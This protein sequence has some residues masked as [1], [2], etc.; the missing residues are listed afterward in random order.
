SAADSALG[1][2]GQFTAISP[3]FGNIGRVVNRSLD[4]M[5]DYTLP[6]QQFGQWRLGLAASRTLE[7]TKQLA[8]GQP[9]VVL[10][11][12]TASPPVWKL[13]GSL[14]WKK[15]AWNAALFYSYLDGFSNNNAGNSLVANS[16]A[17]SYNA[18]PPVTKV[19]T[20]IGYE[21]SHGLWRGHGKG[22][23]VSLG[24]SNLFDKKPPF[25]DTV[26][27]FDAGLHSQFILGRAYEFSFVL[28]Y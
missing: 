8:P 17:V 1:Q 26:W 11:G 12:D 25:S 19:D 9:P 14:F 2:P 10:D 28:P 24:I 20:R 18:T 4:Y 22:A 16:T 3:L 23:R 6:W 21:F 15:G 13:S 5:A 7:A 27:G